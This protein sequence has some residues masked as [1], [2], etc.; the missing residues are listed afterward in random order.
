MTSSGESDK[1]R[2][3]DGETMGN[4]TAT[5][6]SQEIPEAEP[7]EENNELDGNHSVDSEKVFG[8]EGKSEDSNTE[9]VRKPAGKDETSTS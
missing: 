8:P 7:V 2:E 4:L 3:S 6:P 5:G 9:M 1:D